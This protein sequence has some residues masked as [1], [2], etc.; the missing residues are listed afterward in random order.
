VASGWV[1]PVAGGAALD[2]ARRGCWAWWREE[3]GLSRAGALPL[4]SA[5]DEDAADADP[6]RVSLYDDIRPLLV[7]LRTPQ[8]QRELL[9]EFG[10][11]LEAHPALPPPLDAP[12]A[13]T[14]SSSSVAAAASADAA[15]IAPHVSSSHPLAVLRSAFDDAAALSDQS[16]GAGSGAG[17]GG[18]TSAVGR[19]RHAVLAHATALF[20]RDAALAAAYLHSA[21]PPHGP[22]VKKAAKALLR[23]QPD[24]LPLYLAY[25]AAEQRAGRAAE[26]ARILQAALSLGAQPPPPPVAPQPPAVSQPAGAPQRAALAAVA[27]ALARLWLE[28]ALPP[29]RGGSAA[30]MAV[31]ALTQVWVAEAA[32]DEGGGPVPRPFVLRARLGYQ[33]A[34]DAALLPPP[35]AAPPPQPLPPPPQP[36]P[37]RRRP[38][39]G[40][41]ARARASTRR[42]SST[43]RG[44]CA[45][46]PPR[47]PRRPRGC[48]SCSHSAWPPFPPTPRS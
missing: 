12:Y 19:F 25:A 10:L 6:E 31:R 21:A 26:A 15:C 29:P 3:E 11:F 44:C 45:A 37:P 34:F 41:A 14:T 42:C 40:C 43:T 33:Q 2:A 20:P 30:D 18:A 5:D 28:S 35:Q 46:T 36:L 13:A 22:G 24:A 39:R 23:Q 47:T 38:R 48:A 1:P 7:Q 9:L 16:G 4:L 32:A 27:H 8:A 17:G